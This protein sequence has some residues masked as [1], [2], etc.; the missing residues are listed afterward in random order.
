MVFED[1]AVLG[2]LFAA[3]QRKSQL[4][5]VLSIYEK[6]RK[7]RAMEMRRRSRAIREIYAMKDGPLQEERDRQLLEHVPFDGYPN[8]LADP[9]LQKWMFGYKAIEEAGKAWQ[10]YRRGEWPGTSGLWKN[11]KI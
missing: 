8:Y 1:A 10:K 6:V 5:D 3:I 4:P 7:P 2:V 11:S 9:V